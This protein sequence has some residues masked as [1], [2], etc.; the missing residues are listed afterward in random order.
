VNTSEQIRPEV[1][2]EIDYLGLSR[3]AWRYRLFLTII[4]AVCGLLAAIYAFK[5]IPI[6]RAETTLIPVR[7][8]SMAGTSSVIDQLGGIASIAGVNL[9]TADNST[10]EAEAILQSRSLAEAFITRYDLLPALLSDRPAASRTTWAGVEHFKDDVLGIRE[11]ARKG[12]TTIAIDWTDPVV[13]ARWANGYVALANEV[14]RSSAIEESTKNIAYLNKQIS[15][16]T[17]VELQRVMYNLV[18]SETKT[19]MLANARSEY[20]F[21][22]VDPAVPPERRISPKRT[23]IVAV[24]LVTGLML[25]LL[26]A[27]AHDSIRRSNQPGP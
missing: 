18:E 2:D 21:T 6:Y 19:L 23:V 16:T 4:V 9:S 20:A 14:I 22:V 10:L 7:D 17:V 25:G 15:Q 12:T 11:D 27:F 8:R 26:A 3:I 13:A 24:G 5:A 1:D